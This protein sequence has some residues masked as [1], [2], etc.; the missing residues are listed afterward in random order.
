MYYIHI[1][2]IKILLLLLFSEFF[3][4]RIIIIIIFSIVCISNDPFESENLNS[5]LIFYKKRSLNKK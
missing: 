3:F 2:K 4:I 5:I 1:S